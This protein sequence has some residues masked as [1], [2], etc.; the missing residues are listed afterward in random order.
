MEEVYPPGWDRKSESER[1][2]WRQRVDEGRENISRTARERGMTQG[3]AESAA[4]AYE[5]RVRRGEDTREAE[6]A[7]RERVRRGERIRDRPDSVIEETLSPPAEEGGD[8]DGRP[9]RRGGGS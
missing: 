8:R 1:Q 2:E 3:E 4:D 6:G 7:I 9:R 5:E